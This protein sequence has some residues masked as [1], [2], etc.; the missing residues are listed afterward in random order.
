M[1]G[2]YYLINQEDFFD[3]LV[4]LGHVAKGAVSVVPF[5]VDEEYVVSCSIV[6]F[7][8]CR[9]TLKLSFYPGAGC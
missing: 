8:I 1:Y 5:F 6:F 9:I 2:F 4:S 7:S 3:N